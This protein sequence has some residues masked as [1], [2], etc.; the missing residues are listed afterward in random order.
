MT[1]NAGVLTASITTLLEIM[2]NKAE[3]MRARLESAETLLA[4]ES[5]E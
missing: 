4:Y 2:G 3:S 1:D 5:S